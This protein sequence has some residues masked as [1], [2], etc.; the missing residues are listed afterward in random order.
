MTRKNTLAFINEEALSVHASV[1]LSSIFVS[2]SGEWRVGGFEILS[3][4]KDD[5]AIIYVCTPLNGSI[6]VF[7]MGLSPPT[8]QGWATPP[9][10]I[11]SDNPRNT[12]PYPLTVDGMPRLKYHDLGGRLLNAIHYLRLIHMTSRCWS[13]KSSTGVR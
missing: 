11:K 2:Q 6:E 12:V 7:V 3:S 8:S 5:E 4:M 10:T 9:R 13:L 1:K